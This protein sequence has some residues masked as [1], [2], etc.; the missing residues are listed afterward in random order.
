MA[1][2]FPRTYSNR[3]CLQKLTESRIFTNAASSYPLDDFRAHPLYREY[4]FAQAGPR[5]RLVNPSGVL[6]K[7]A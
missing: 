7:A 1:S 4:G 5:G 6:F 2:C 3:I